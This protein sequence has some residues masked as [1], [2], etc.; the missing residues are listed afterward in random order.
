MSRSGLNASLSANAVTRTCAQAC[1]I[2]V[3]TVTL[4]LR[5]ATAL[6]LGWP[7]PAE[8]DDAALEAQLFPSAAPVRDRIALDAGAHNGDLGAV[9]HV[10]SQCRGC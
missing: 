7:L 2:S 9:I 4:Y 6:G 5:R 10:R 1:A 8:L 3:G